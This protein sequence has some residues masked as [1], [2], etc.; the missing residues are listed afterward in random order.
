MGSQRTLV[1]DT[2][3]FIAGFNPSAVDCDLYSVPEVE[4]ELTRADLLKVRFQ[5]A[6]ESGKLKILL[7]DVRFLDAVREASKE[8]GDMRY[9]SEA[10]MHVIALAA[11]LKDEE[12]SPTIVTD[13]YSIQNM[14]TK[15][16]VTFT[17]SATLGIRYQLQWL[18]YC[19]ACR[20][21]YPSDYKYRDCEICGTRLK[22]KPQ[23]KKPAIEQV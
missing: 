12:R 8:M 19:P 2:S 15:I 23:T 9:L 21:K 16:G 11:Q 17:S 22:R 18:L 13:D 4:R 6:V 7:P 5:A 1:L 10:D 14:A 20:R 3:A